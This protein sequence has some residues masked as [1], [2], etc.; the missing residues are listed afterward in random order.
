M[1]KYDV[2]D[3]I[4]FLHDVEKHKNFI[5]YII[6]IC[7]IL[8]S[9]EET[10]TLMSA[11]MSVSCTPLVLCCIE[12]D[13]MFC[14]L[15]S[16][17]VTQNVGKLSKSPRGTARLY[18]TIGKLSTG[19]TCHYTA[20]CE[21]PTGTACLY[22]AICKLSTGTTCHYTAIC[23]L[24]TGTTCLYTA[25]CELPTGTTCLYAAVCELP[26]GTNCSNTAKCGQ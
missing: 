16:I 4:Y 7:S 21:L 12:I 22:T 1:S 17:T 8:E 20:I 3:T 23:E 13:K 19:T 2:K 10:L 26:T 5:K 11:H 25:I 9:K 18:T 14:S 24:P 15:V 6:V